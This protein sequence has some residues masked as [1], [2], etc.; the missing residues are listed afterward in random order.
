MDYIIINSDK[1]TASLI[2]TEIAQLPGCSVS[3]S[4]RRNL[5]AT[6]A[7]MIVAISVAAIKTLP[8]VLD[9]LR[10]YAESKRIDRIVFKGLEI[11]KPTESQVDQIIQH[12]ANQKQEDK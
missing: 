1:E 3:K 11:N 12:L 2:E 6:T 10:K 8:Q 7:G 4:E 5:D 9:I